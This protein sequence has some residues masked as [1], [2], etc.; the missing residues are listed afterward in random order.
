MDEIR[1]GHVNENLP[2]V[3]EDGGQLRYSDLSSRNKEAE[4]CPYSSEM[5]DHY[6]ILFIHKIPNVFTHSDG[7]CI[8]IPQKKAM[9]VS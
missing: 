9:H 8:Y 6:S 1:S 4:V 3:E 7:H 2:H 5:V